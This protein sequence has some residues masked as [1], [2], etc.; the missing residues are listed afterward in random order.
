LRS[1]PGDG[2]TIDVTLPAGASRGKPA[3][4]LGHVRR[5]PQ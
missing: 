2:T 1:A 3:P 4:L 5:R